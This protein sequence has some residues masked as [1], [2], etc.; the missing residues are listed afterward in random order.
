M[1][2]T[3]ARVENYRGFLDSSDLHFDAG[4]N[5]VVGRNGSGKSAL[6]FALSQRLEGHPHRSTTSIPEPGAV[7][8]PITQVVVRHSLT[9][10]ELRSIALSGE[11]GQLVVPIPNEMAGLPTGNAKVWNSYLQAEFEKN[12]IELNAIW[13]AKSGTGLSAIPGKPSARHG[14]AVLGDASN[15]GQMQAICYRV[16]RDRKNFEFY[17]HSSASQSSDCYHQIA[18]ACR[19]R[20]FRFDAE[21]LRIGRGVYGTSRRLAADAS[22]LPEVLQNLRTDDARF[23]EY[24]SLVSEVLPEVRDIRIVPLSSSEQEICVSCLASET[25]RPDLAVPLRYTGSGVSQVLAILCVIVSADL[26]NV[27][28]IDEPNSFLHPQASRALVRILKRYPQHQYIIA[29]HSPEVIAEVGD[30]K[31][32]LLEWKDEATHALQLATENARA[33]SQALKVVGAKLSDVYGYDRIVWCEGPSDAQVLRKIA[34]HFFKDL[35]GVAI[36]PVHST[37]AFD[38]RRRAETIGMYRILSCANALLPPTVG[39]LFDLEDRGESD[40]A[41]LERATDIKVRFLDRRMIENFLLDADAIRELLQALD[42][43]NEVSAE[44]IRGW[45]ENARCNEEFCS[46]RITATQLNLDPLKWTHGKR[47]LNLA[48][49]EFTSGR[50]SFINTRD[51]EIL[52]SYVLAKSP[53]SLAPVALVLGDLFGVEPTAA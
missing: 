11:L 13:R 6:L 45:L 16:T 33:S 40:R 50:H 9:G 22:N 3:H 28:L 27:I 12:E 26:P 5:L 48:I 18:Q 23:R 44:T 31:T 37:G 41:D 43:G 20:I 14:L 25:R 29:T 30:A 53:A 24:L 47:L 46:Q 7:P 51:A 4:F 21:R 35:R 42:P 49:V 34:D 52:A 32:T 38:K 39:F 10:K 15:E 8:N 2:I 17:S 36:V 19:E 1:L